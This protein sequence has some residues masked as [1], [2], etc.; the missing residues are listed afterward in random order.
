MRLATPEWPATKWSTAPPRW[1]SRW[2]APP[3]PAAAVALNAALIAKVAASAKPN[4]RS[5]MLRRMIFLWMARLR[6]GSTTSFWDWPRFRP[7]SRNATTTR[8]R[9]PFRAGTITCARLAH[10]PEKACPREG[11]GC[12]L[13]GQDHAQNQIVNADAVVGMAF[14]GIVDFDA[15]VG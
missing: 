12:R 9:R 7:L 8:Q 1:L 13:F 10:D 11:G 5:M 14:R 2:L 15:N 4:F 6:G 3:P